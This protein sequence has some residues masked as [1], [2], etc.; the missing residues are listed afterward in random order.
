MS[1]DGKWK[2]HLPH[3]YRTLETPGMDGL[4]GRYV[5]ASIDT[6]LFDMEQDPY[7]TTNVLDQYPEVAAQLIDMAEQHKASFYAPAP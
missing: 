2:L 1:G 7:E 5:Q 6:A 4:A 3:A